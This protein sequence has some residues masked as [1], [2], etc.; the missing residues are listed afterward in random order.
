MFIN[1]PLRK[2]SVRCFPVEIV[3]PVEIVFHDVFQI[4]SDN[5]DSYLRQIVGSAI[6]R[7]NHSSFVD[8]KYRN[9]LHPFSLFQFQKS[10]S[11]DNRFYRRSKLKSEK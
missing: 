8:T 4:N 1:E 3:S 2:A 10:S 5:Y 6:N 9:L 7:S 11:L